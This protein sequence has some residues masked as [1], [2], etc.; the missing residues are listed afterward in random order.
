MSSRDNGIILAAST[1]AFLAALVLAVGRGSLPTASGADGRPPGAPPAGGT[2]LRIAVVDVARVFE[3]YGKKKEI[4][5]RLV[6]EVAEAEK[7]YKSR[8]EAKEFTDALKEKQ[9]AA[10]AELREDILKEIRTYAEVKKIDLVIEKNVTAD[11]VH[12]PIVHHARAGLDITAEIIRR[13]NA[14]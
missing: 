14:S 13:L 1:I 9:R 10:L 2:N 12:W 4:E 6:A 11:E 8:E 3:G 5:D 7:K